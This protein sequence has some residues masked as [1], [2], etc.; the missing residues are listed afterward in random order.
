MLPQQVGEL[1]KLTPSTE[2]RKNIRFASYILSENKI[3]AD[4][5]SRIKNIDIEWE[6]NELIFQEICLKLGQL[7]IDLFASYCNAKCKTIIS[8]KPEK[9]AFA[10]D[11]FT[12]K[13][14]KFFFYDFLPFSLIT[15]ILSKIKKDKAEGIIIVPDWKNKPWFPLFNQLTVDKQLIFQPDFKML[16]SPCRTLIHPRAD[17]LRLI[18]SKVSAGKHL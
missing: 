2:C 7:N 1:Q 12:I 14:S 15:R 13:W 11:A 17:H 5:F 4:R 3:I 8:W 10:I 16:L 6:L 9:E 18:A